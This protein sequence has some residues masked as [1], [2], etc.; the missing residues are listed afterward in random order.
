MKQEQLL[1]ACTT[2]ELL[3]PLDRYGSVQCVC[4]RR[5]RQQ[6][7]S[8]D[9]RWRCEYL[10]RWL[11]KRMRQMQTLYPLGQ[12]RPTRFSRQLRS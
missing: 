11:Q 1:R 6:F 4:A 10:H 2:T 12:G 7:V 5:V 8:P 3:L 9:V